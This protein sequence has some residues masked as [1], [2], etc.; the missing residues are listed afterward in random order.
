MTREEADQFLERIAAWAEKE[1][2][3]TGLLLV[4]SFARGDFRNSSDLDVVVLTKR[5][6]RFLEDCKWVQSFGSVGKIQQETW[7]I[8]TSLRVHYDSG[9]E[10]EFGIVPS[11]WASVDAMDPGTLKVVRNGARIVWDP[12]EDL[13]QLLKMAAKY[14]T[15]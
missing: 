6:A 4:G 1:P 13:K 8:M 11:T 5:P 9:A 15:S 7:G 2:L 12:H 10:I 3:V 14:L